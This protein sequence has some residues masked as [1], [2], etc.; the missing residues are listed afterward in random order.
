[1][2]STNNLGVR[3]P[4][5]ITKRQIV[6]VNGLGDTRST[7]G[8]INNSEGGV[9]GDESKVVSRWG[10]LYGL[11]PSSSI[12]LSK[13]FLTKRQSL[14]ER[15]VLGAGI[16]AFDEGREHT[17]LEVSGSSSNKDISRMPVD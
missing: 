7:L 15:G 5:K 9:L 14:S 8:N 6:N 1:M 16:H 11:N 13:N 2:T 4:V 3:D 12:V 10:P 17:N